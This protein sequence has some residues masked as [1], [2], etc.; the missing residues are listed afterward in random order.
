MKTEDLTSYHGL[1]GLVIRKWTPQNVIFRIPSPLRDPYR[2]NSIWLHS[3]EFNF[4]ERFQAQ[5]RKVS[6][7]TS[8]SSSSRPSRHLSR[9]CSCGVFIVSLHIL[10]SPE[11]SNF[12]CDYDAIQ[13]PWFFPSQTYTMRASSVCFEIHWFTWSWERKGNRNLTL[14]SS[15]LQGNSG[16]TCR[17]GGGGGSACMYS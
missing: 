14:Q 12:K 1:N 16:T 3:F 6:H 8:E 7:I 10:K 9:N 15:C 2:Y 13:F 5:H 4:S 11:H 17:A